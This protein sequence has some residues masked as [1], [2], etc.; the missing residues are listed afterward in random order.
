MEQFPGHIHWTVAQQ[1]AV[2]LLKSDP[3]MADPMPHE[4]QLRQHGIQYMAI[5]DG[6]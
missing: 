2:H 1:A 6:W 4:L 5:N 3:M